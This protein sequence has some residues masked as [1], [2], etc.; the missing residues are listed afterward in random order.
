MALR[1][2]Q[3]IGRYSNSQVREGRTWYRN[4][5]EPLV[6]LGHDVELFLLDEARRAAW[7]GNKRRSNQIGEQLLLTL[8]EAHQVRPIDLFFCYAIDGMFPPE[9]VDEVRAL[10]IITCNFSC[11]NTHQ[12][13][14]TRNLAPHFDFNLHSERDAAEKFIAIG[15]IPMWWPM[16][17]N[18]KY[19]HPVQ[20]PKDIDVSF[21]GA[22]YALRA[23]YIA[24]LRQR[25]VDV[26]AS[27]PGWRFGARSKWRAHVLRL[28]LLR[29]AILARSM[30]DKRLA[31]ARLAELDYQRWLGNTFPANLHDPISDDDLVAM[32]SRSRV[33]L[34]FL[35]VF[36]GHDPMGELRR[37]VHLREFEAPMCGALYLTGHCEELETFFEPDREVLVYRS[38][39]ELADK[40]TFYLGHPEACEQIRLAGRRRAL[41]DHTYHKRYRSLLE[42]LGLS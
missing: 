26:H 10:G 25:G 16:A 37:H 42:A 38:S 20:T 19:F 4:L 21:V 15:A 5:Y 24:G 14:L 23:R 33:S 2:F 41:A 9:V 7:E 40:V 18:P 11:N 8:R 27:G 3:A 32:Y 28:I 39:E 29:R 31:S 13:S 36:D 22:S 1:V 12:F 17:S 30:T 6:D 35:E 34:G